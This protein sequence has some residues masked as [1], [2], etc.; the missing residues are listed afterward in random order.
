M[1]YYREENTIQHFNLSHFNVPY[2]GL[3]V[4]PPIC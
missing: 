2:E 4:M 1:L 3:P